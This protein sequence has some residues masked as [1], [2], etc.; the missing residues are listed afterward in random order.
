M[1]QKIMNKKVI[2]FDCDGTLV[3]TFLLIE[4]TVLKTF[5]EMLPNY[6][7]TLKEVH[8]FF[9]PYLNDSFKKY[10]KNK[11]EVINLVECYRRINAKLMPIYIKSYNGIKELLENLKKKNYILAIVSNKET[12]AVIKSLQFCQIDDYFDLIIGAEKLK[13][14][15]PNPDGIYQVLR[16]YPS[17]DAYMV[18]DAITD[19]Q[20]GKDAH[21]KTIGVT[22]CQTSKDDFIKMG[23]T[24]VVDQPDEILKI[25]SE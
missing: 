6:P 3:D 9:G 17:D 20:S 11:E 25:V 7:L 22:W 18:G 19:I 15:K 4:K 5:E 24:F 21:I 23:A 10:A 13:F 8:H 14:A 12:Q 2:I 16:Q 1:V